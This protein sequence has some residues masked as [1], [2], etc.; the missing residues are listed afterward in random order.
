MGRDGQARAVAGWGMAKRKLRI[1]ERRNNI[2][3]LGVCEFCNMQFHIIRQP[4]RPGAGFRRI[5]AWAGGSS[6]AQAQIQQQFNAHKCKLQDFA[7]NA[8]RIVTEA[9]EKK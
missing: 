4:Q 5:D 9:T 6:E 7:Q 8:A 2:P 3:V 1:V